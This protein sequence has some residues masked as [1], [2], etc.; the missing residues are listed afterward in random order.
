MAWFFLQQFI[1]VKIRKSEKILKLNSSE[2]KLLILV[3][4]Y[5]IVYLLY[6]IISLVALNSSSVDSISNVVDYL[7]CEGFGND[8]NKPC[9][10]DIFGNSTVLM[11]AIFTLLLNGLSPAVY[12][13]YVVNTQKIKEIICQGIVWC[14]N[15][16]KISA[17]KTVK[18]LHSQTYI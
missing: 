9:N 8:P 15:R 7:S 12:L 16:R 6:W 3:C 18:K 14:S 11:Y 10:A 4:Y 5:V 1:F 17:S 13:M 2:V